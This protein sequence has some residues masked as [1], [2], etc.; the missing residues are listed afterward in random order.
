M[1]GWRARLGM[2]LPTNNTVLEPEAALW[3]PP[4]VTAHATRMVSSRT[5][6]G[7]VEGLRHLVTHVDRALDEFAITGVDAVLYGCLSTSLVHDDWEDTFSRKAAETANVPAATAFGAVVAALE[8]VAARRIAVLCPYGKEI[9][10][11]VAPAFGRQGFEV[12]A[13]YSLEVTGLRAVCNVDPLELYRAARRLELEGADA[14]VILATD[15]P[16]FPILNDL[17]AALTV[18]VV[19][20]NQA[21]LWRAGQLVGIHQDNPFVPLPKEALA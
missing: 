2:L 6:H 19:A 14:L 3:A 9:Q 15:L 20:T 18:P 16:T 8:S 17:R 1:Y 11:L 5:G 4:G 21:L 13:L 12:A 10:A 7:S